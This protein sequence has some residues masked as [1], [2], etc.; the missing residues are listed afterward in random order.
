MGEAGVRAITSCEDI[1]TGMPVYIYGTGTAGRTIFARIN[2][3]MCGVVQGFVD[4]SARG[5][6]NGLPILDPV[7]DRDALNGAAILIAS[8]AW[9]EIGNRLVRLGFANVYNAYPLYTAPA[10]VELDDGFRSPDLRA[11]LI[12]Q[13]ARSA[14]S[15]RV[16]VVGNNNSASGLV[17]ALRDSE[18]SAKIVRHYDIGAP[19]SDDTVTPI[20]PMLND[21]SAGRFDAIVLAVPVSD[22]RT[23]IRRVRIVQSVDAPIWIP[24]EHLDKA[25]IPVTNDRLEGS[26]L[27]EIREELSESHGMPFLIVVP[28]C[29]GTMRFLPQIEYLL[30]L[31]GWTPKPF[32]PLTCNPFFFSRFRSGMGRS[33]STDSGALA[34]CYGKEN[35]EAYYWFSKSLR[36]NEYTVLHDHSID[37]RRFAD[38]PHKV[39]VLMRD[40]RDIF[41]SIFYRNYPNERKRR[42]PESFML[43]LLDGEDFFFSPEYGYRWGS[44][45]EWTDAYLAAVESPNIEVVR[46]EDL[47][48][49]E[50][51]T[52]RTLLDRLGLFPNPFVEITDD[53]LR[54]AA[55]LGSFEHQTNGQA[56]RGEERQGIVGQTSCRKGVVGD[57]RATFTPAVVDKFKR[58]TGDALTRLGYEDSMGW[59]LEG[60]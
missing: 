32:M 46:F 40:P 24:K 12:H 43:D 19:K 45:T 60:S 6:I 36:H 30:G 1:P 5:E 11:D 16:A 42:S 53:I 41:N 2:A 35:T 14:E 23:A 39:V 52:L 50:V 10:D 48:R 34:E 54:F 57:W 51:G 8:Q 22:V 7:A 33:A 29:A 4:G 47:H 49:D 37:F 38:L 17:A 31:T 21:Y 55:H 25:G 27:V 15:A 9:A 28:P 20:G 44:A 3:R 26:R 59:G 56:S 58:L 18:V 13:I